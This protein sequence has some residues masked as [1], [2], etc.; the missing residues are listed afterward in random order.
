MKI[1]INLILFLLGVALLI[2]AIN[3]VDMEKTLGLLMEMK[4]GFL[5][6]LLLYS[7]ITWVDTIS[8]KYNFPP[9]VAKAFS[10]RRLW[11]VRLIGDAYNTITPLGTMG[12]E[13]VKAHLLKEHCDIS[14]KQ[15]LSSLIIA[16]TA[17]LTAL[18]LFC[19]PGIFF[20]LNSADIP[21]DFKTASLLGLVSFSIMIF[22][23][24]LFQITGT[25]GKICQWIAFKTNK[26]GLQN[27]L[28]KLV[29]LDKLFSVYYRNSHQRIFISIFYALWGWILGIGE[30]YLIF[31]FLGFSPSFIDIWIIEAMAQLVK[32][33]SFFI[34]FSIGALEGGM[35]LIF[36]SLGYP[37]SLG[38]AASLIG[39][40]KQLAWVALGLTA[41]WLMAFKSTKI[42]SES[43]E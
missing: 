13:P 3:S 36:S 31:Y 22:L 8:W 20:I 40:I 9:E 27:F 12:G 19:I 18:I 28:E 42:K 4:F 21:A 11:V 5:A 39:R 26:P 37:A 35:V 32:A 23:F 1:F 33:G 17:F 7:L 16:R 41:G 2:W 10:I 6:I 29:Q 15:T 38:L 25:L 34:P 24:F 14:L 43:L 30:V